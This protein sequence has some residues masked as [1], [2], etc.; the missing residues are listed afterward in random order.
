M[1]VD[2][3]LKIEGVEGESKDSVHQK[4]IEL[5][6]WSWGETQTGRAAEGAGGAVGT[7][8]PASFSFRKRVDMSGTKLNQLC[9]AGKYVN[10]AYFTA[11]RAGAADGKPV[12]YLKIHFKGVLIDSYSTTGSGGDS[13]PLESISFK[14]EQMQMEYREVKDGMPGGPVPAG[15]NFKQNKKV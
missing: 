10:N 6:D 1:A 11:R 2:Y 5:E 8:T 15:F 7:V 14:F 4:E 9:A 13:P 3:F 12:D